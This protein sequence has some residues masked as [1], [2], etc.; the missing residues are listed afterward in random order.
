VVD[1]HGCG[2]KWLFLS[3]HFS[4]RET[5]GI[6]SHGFGLRHACSIFCANVHSFF[7]H[8]I[9]PA[10]KR[11][12]FSVMVLVLDMS[13]LYAHKHKYSKELAVPSIV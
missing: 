4:C 2:A 6:F 7:G 8:D 10:A 13:I 1:Y 12:A 5:F 3:W 11:S 9:F